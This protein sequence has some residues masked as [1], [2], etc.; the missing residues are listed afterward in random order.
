MHKLAI[1]LFLPIAFCVSATM[2]A[3]LSAIAADDSQQS[4]LP[5]PYQLTA[6]WPTLPAGRIWGA[7][8]A[9]DI[10]PKGHIW[11]AERCGG[12]TCDGKTEDPILEFDKSGKLLKSFGSGLFIAPHGIYCDKKGNIWITD[13]QGK[14]GKGQQVFK[15]SPDGKVLMTLGKAGVAGDGPDTFNQPDDVVVGRND[16]IFVSDGHTPGS[17]NARV[18]KFSKDGKFIKQWG[19]H[20]SGP[21]Q[22]EVPHALAID[23]KGRLIVGDLGNSRLQ[24]FDQD[25]KFITEWK[26]F[27]RASGIFIDKHGRIYVTDASSVDKPGAGYNP[28]FQQGITIGNVKD[29]KA[30]AFIPAPPSPTNVVTAPE[31]VAADGQGTIYGA[32]VASKNV[33]RYAKK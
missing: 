13:F 31:G 3:G 17:G 32:E 2:L 24:V 20:G 8:G 6:N 30:I 25:G 23:S 27:G 18:I 12:T 15:F 14:N 9:I 5:N 26:Q 21:G 1:K 33:L 16:D 11:I 10:D 28:G 22:F 7:T 19:G 29:G 4:H